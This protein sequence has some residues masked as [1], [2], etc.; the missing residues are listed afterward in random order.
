MFAFHTEIDTL[1]D[2]AWDKMFCIPK[3]ATELADE[4]AQKITTGGGADQHVLILV[5]PNK[6]EYGDNVYSEMRKQQVQYFEQVIK[7]KNPLLKISSRVVKRAVDFRTAVLDAAPVNTVCTIANV[8]NQGKIEFSDGAHV[9]PNQLVYLTDLPHSVAEK[10]DVKYVHF[11]ATQTADKDVDG[12]KH[13]WAPADSH[14]GD[15]TT[16]RRVAYN[17]PRQL[18]D[19]Q[20]GWVHSALN[21]EVLAISA[22]AEYIQEYETSLDLAAEVERKYYNEHRKTELRGYRDATPIGPLSPGPHVAP[23]GLRNEIRARATKT[24][25]QFQTEY[26]SKQTQ[27]AYVSALRRKQYAE[28]HVQ[29]TKKTQVNKYNMWNDLYGNLYTKAY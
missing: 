4:T 22:V 25:Q 13:A 20:A 11:F 3:G 5:V 28:Q 17:I 1:G 29:S 15:H 21:P 26:L 8:D 24:A 9:D 10:R 14:H 18:V 23:V 19:G 6:A 12:A 7:I 2:Y 27:H 16:L